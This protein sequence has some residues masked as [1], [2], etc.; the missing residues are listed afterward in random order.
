MVCFFDSSTL[1]SL[2]TT[3]SLDILEKLQ[4]DYGAEFGITSTVKAETIDKAKT[5]LRFAYEGA[6]LNRLLEKGVLKLF[7]DAK[8]KPEINSAL[9][10]I[11]RIFYARGRPLEI[12]HGGEVS[13]FVLAR[14]L[15]ADAYFVDERTT[16]VLLENP[17]QMQD[18]LMGKLHEQVKINSEMMNQM[19]S[20]GK[21]PV[22]RSTELAIAAFE[23]GYL[24]TKDALAGLLWALKFAGCAISSD[25]INEYVRKV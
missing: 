8:Y 23:K 11:N 24:D 19:K 14:E 1:I 17:A 7:D 4:K 22:L 16:R 6:R 9:S 25:E 20:M 15:G 13:A 5:T 21:I 12:V 18:I 2:A 10:C 3:C